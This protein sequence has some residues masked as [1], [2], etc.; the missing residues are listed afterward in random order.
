MHLAS[1]LWSCVCAGH[2]L[3]ESALELYLSTN[4]YLYVEDE[5]V[6]PKVLAFACS[7]FAV[8]N[9]D[10]APVWTR[11]CASIDLAIRL[12][13]HKP[14]Q[15]CNRMANYLSND[16]HQ[17]SHSCSWPVVCTQ[18]D[19]MMEYDAI[20]STLIAI[21]LFDGQTW[22]TLLFLC[23]WHLLWSKAIVIY[24]V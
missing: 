6:L 12:L 8:N 13:C 1:L 9:S 22:V 11:P 21:N 18:S 23:S 5:R 19:S 16:S 3:F 7:C 2:C 4:T 17:T 14:S 15:P 20:P 10:W 24:Y